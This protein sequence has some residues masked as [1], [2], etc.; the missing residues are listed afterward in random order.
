MTLHRGARRAMTLIEVMAALAIGGL[1]L[2]SGRALL[3]QLQDAGT[4]LGRS[5]RANDELANATRTLHALVRR[6]DVRPD[7]ASRFIGDS[8][9]ASFRTLCE[10]SG[11]W[12][13]PCGVTV[14]IDVGPD[15]SS[16]VGQLSIGGLLI[17]KR[18]P[19]VGRF[20]YLDV[21]GAQDQWVSQWGRSIVPPAAMALVVPP[22][23]IV[24]P[25][26]GR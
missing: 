16:L 20:R 18:W 25:V 24:L 21:T 8:L 10:Q 6:A 19:G 2:M 22:D 3:G 12:L 1:L 17:L 5:A 14:L 11:G 9:S 7:S 23:T 4:T 15:S 13:E 26:A